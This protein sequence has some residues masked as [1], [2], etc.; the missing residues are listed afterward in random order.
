MWV[1]KST[2]FCLHSPFD[3]FRLSTAAVHYYDGTVVNMAQ[4]QAI[5]DYLTLIAR[6][7]SPPSLQPE[8]PASLLD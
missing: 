3:K 6:R 8:T 1:S 2:I 4:V 7:A 5:A